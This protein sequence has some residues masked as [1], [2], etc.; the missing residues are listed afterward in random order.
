VVG[1]ATPT[2]SNDAPHV[3]ARAVPSSLIR[4]ISLSKLLGV[5]D[6]FVVMDVIA[7]ARAVIVTASQ[8]SVLIVGVAELVIVVMRGV[9]RLLVNVC[10]SLV[11]TIVPLGAVAV[12]NGDVPLPIK[13][14]V[15][16]PAPLPPRATDSVPVQPSV[17]DVEVM[18]APVGVPPSVN[19]TFVSLVLVMSPNVPTPVPPRPAA[20]VPVHPSVND[21]DCSNAVVGVP[22]KVTVTLVSFVRVNAAGVIAVP[23][24][25]V[26]FDPAP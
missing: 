3:I 5:P 8:L 9:T 7:A 22:P 4:K 21:V 19:V 14:P 13:T 12:V 10:V 18:T 17:K 26:G 2:A 11:P 15:N 24:A 1:R 16:V 25:Q 23:D 6:K 20:S